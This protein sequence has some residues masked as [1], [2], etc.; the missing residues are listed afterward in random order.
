MTSWKKKYISS[1]AKISFK[2]QI[3]I[4][5]GTLHKKIAMILR[6]GTSYLTF[7]AKRLKASLSTVK[8]DTNSLANRFRNIGRLITLGQLRPHGARSS[9]TSTGG[10]VSIGFSRTVMK[11]AGQRSRLTT[12]DQ[13]T[14]T[15]FEQTVNLLSKL[16]NYNEIILTQRR[17]NYN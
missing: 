12:D 14:I 8:R 1:S 13:R 9:R 4:T 10:S 3:A 5:F 6:D 16:L 17:L 11:L 2:Q 7:T 15:L